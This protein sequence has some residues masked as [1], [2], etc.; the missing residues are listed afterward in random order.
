MPIKRFAFRGLR[1]EI[2]PTRKNNFYMSKLNVRKRE[3]LKIHSI[4]KEKMGICGIKICIC[5]FYVRRLFDENFLSDKS[6]PQHRKK[7][8][9]QILHHI[10]STKSSKSY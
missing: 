6:A 8:I 5:P 2:G 3:I 1:L 10:F 7:K 4:S 9:F